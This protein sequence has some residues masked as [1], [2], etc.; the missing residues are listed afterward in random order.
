MWFLYGRAVTDVIAMP[1]DEWLNLDNRLVD[2]GP[3]AERLRE[4]LGLLVDAAVAPR[5][6]SKS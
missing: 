1:F 5:P 2:V 3:A 6:R 4:K